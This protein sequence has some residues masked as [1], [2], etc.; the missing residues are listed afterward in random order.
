MARAR[1]QIGRGVCVRGRRGRDPRV[2]SYMRLMAACLTVLRGREDPPAPVPDSFHTVCRIINKLLYCAPIV[3]RLQP[4]ALGH[5][6]N[7]RRTIAVLGQAHYCIYETLDVVGVLE[8]VASQ[9]KVRRRK[10]A[11]P[12]RQGGCG[13]IAC[14]TPVATWRWEKSC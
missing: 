12:G 1:P 2:A 4:P 6:E 10:P 13:Q 14:A 5:V 8:Q 7:V 9:Q 11:Y 3:G